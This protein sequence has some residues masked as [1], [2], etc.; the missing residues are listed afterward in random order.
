MELLLAWLNP[1]VA[2]Q[3]ASSKS[4][5]SSSDSSSSSR[6]GSKKE[7]SLVAG[8]ATDGKTIFDLQAKEGAKAAAGSLDILH[9][10]VLVQFTGQSKPRL[11]CSG[12]LHTKSFCT[13]F[14]QS[15][16][17]ACLQKLA[18]GAAEVAKNVPISA[19]H[20]VHQVRLSS[21]GILDSADNPP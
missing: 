7:A 13:P 11:K 5:S 10:A 9:A 4:S 21:F 3:G 19:K 20:Q 6:K 12:T 15:L 8:G 14:F 17:G 1:L 2:S 18:N 16:S